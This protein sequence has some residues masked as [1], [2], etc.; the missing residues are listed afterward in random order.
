[1][2][3]L[4]AC[5]AHTDGDTKSVPDTDTATD[6]ATDTDTAP[7][8]DLCTAADVLDGTLGESWW[9]AP[10]GDPVFLVTPQGAG[11]WGEDCYGGVTNDVLAVTAGA[12]AW[13]GHT[14]EGA[15]SA[16]PQDVTVTGCVTET[17][18]EV[19]ILTLAGDPLWGPWDL[20]RSATMIDYEW[21][22]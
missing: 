9:A 18:M 14:S 4:L 15:G 8:D 2:L 22:D 11:Y 21:C 17:R 12:F 10:S 16:P 5:A 7:P 13:A 6:T 19:T 1:M 20:T 3:L